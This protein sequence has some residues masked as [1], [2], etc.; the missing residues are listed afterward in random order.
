MRSAHDFPLRN[1][2]RSVWSLSSFPSLVDLFKLSG[3]WETGNIIEKMISAGYEINIESNKFLFSKDYRL[4]KNSF[5]MNQFYD[6]CH[7]SR[8]KC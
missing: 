5:S 6:K 4:K 7:L 2:D 1:L 3:E 8:M